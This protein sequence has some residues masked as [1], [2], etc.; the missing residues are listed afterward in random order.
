MLGSEYSIP[1]SVKIF[2]EMIVI[3]LGAYLGHFYI[4]ELSHRIVREEAQGSSER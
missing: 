3:N 1:V 4:S 2:E